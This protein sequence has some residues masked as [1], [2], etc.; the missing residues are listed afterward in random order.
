MQ[1]EQ[2]T[3]GGH[4]FE[5]PAFIL[6]IPDPAQELG[7]FRAMGLRMFGDQSGNP[8]DIAVGDPTPLQDP[9]LVHHSR[10]TNL[11]QR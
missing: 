3:A 8:T 2:Q 7:E 5:L 6:P 10:V 9:C 11:P 1:F 4:V